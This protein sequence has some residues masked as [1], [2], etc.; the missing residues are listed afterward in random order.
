MLRLQ[1][2][3]AIQAAALTRKNLATI[4]IEQA[5]QNLKLAKKEFDRIASLLPTGAANQQ[6]YDAA[7][8]S[9]EQAKLAGK[10]TRAAL[11]AADADLARVEA[12]IALLAKQ[13]ADCFP[14]APVRGIIVNK[15]IKAGELA[16]PGAPLLEIARLDTVWVKIYLPPQDLTRLKLGGRAEIDPED[17]RDS[18]LSGHVSWIAAR[19][20]FTPKN[21]Q[22]K[23]ARADLVYAVKI[24]IPNPQQRLKI[25]MPVAVRIP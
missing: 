10:R 14:T 11:A 7:E 2:A 21:V 12:E 4:D 25:G 17:G 16:G 15:F 1:Q 24:T 13:F 6:Q 23:Q 19:A 20:E 3:E 8:N 18:P 22:T 9:Y 5:D